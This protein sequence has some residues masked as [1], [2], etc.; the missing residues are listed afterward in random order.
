MR[1]LSIIL[2]LFAFG[3]VWAQAT[4]TATYT[5]QRSQ[6][7]I[8]LPYNTTTSHDVYG[9]YNTSLLIL[10]RN[11]LPFK[12]ISLSN[13][14]KQSAITIDIKN[15]Q[16]GQDDENYIINY[17]EYSGCLFTDNGDMINSSA[18]T[19]TN[20]YIV[21]FIDNTRT[22]ATLNFAQK[23][24]DYSLLFDRVTDELVR[25]NKDIKYQA[26]LYQKQLRDRQQNDQAKQD[27]RA[28]NDAAIQQKLQDA[29]KSADSTVSARKR[30]TERKELY[31][32]DYLPKVYPLSETDAAK[33]IIDNTIE[34]YFY[35]NDLDNCSIK[36]S[37]TLLVDTIGHVSS[38]TFPPLDIEKMV[39]DDQQANL[40]AL[41]GI[42]SACTNLRLPI[43]TVNVDG[44]YFPVK[45]QLT[46][47]LDFSLVNTRK[48]YH[49]NKADQLIDKDG[50]E[51]D[52]KIKEQFLKIYGQAHQI[53]VT[54]KTRL[55]EFRLGTK[56]TIYIRDITYWDG[57]HATLYKNTGGSSISSTSEED[58]KEGAAP[59]TKPLPSQPTTSPTKP[60]DADELM[61]WKKLLDAGV[62]T[63]Q[64]YEEKKR[65]ILSN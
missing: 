34:A 28:S 27:Q 24:G 5:V 20:L 26:S 3:K 8:K 59:T 23:L 30:D 7:A 64:E 10:D 18:N 2:L 65:K 46:Y 16:T 52:E 11:G 36:T 40:A 17:N 9:N 54:L 57:H 39:N 14:T 47:I 22:Y 61:K 43:T 38:V 12:A 63:P 41:K 37:V 55:H 21:S 29:K 58:A 53:N 50:D 25:V 42:K 1:V 60:S 4:D 32:K 35:S 56:T 13:K 45:S 15:L 19:Y 44:E 49:F 6:T 51:A 48:K 33:R 31:R 62:I